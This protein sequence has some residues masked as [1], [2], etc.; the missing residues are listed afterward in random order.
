MGPCCHGVR[1]SPSRVSAAFVLARVAVGVFNERVA[2][3]QLSLPLGFEIAGKWRV[4][5]VLGAGGMGTVYRARHVRNDRVVALKVLHPA[6][7]TDREA[8]ERFLR[9]GYAANQVGHP[10]TVQVLDDGSTPEGAFLVMDYLEGV[11]IDKLAE[12]HRDVLPLGVVLAIT[13]AALDVLASAHEKGIIHRDLKPENLFLTQQGQLKVLDFGLARVRETQSAVRLTTTGVLMG[14]PAFMPPEQALAHWDT[15]EASSDVFSVG[16]TMWTL[17]TGRLVHEAAS[18]TELLV[19]AAMNQVVGVASVL[20]DLPGPVADV[21]DRSLAF[22]RSRRFAHAGEMAAALRLAVRAAH[23]SVPSLASVAA[24]VSRTSRQSTSQD[25]QTLRVAPTA[26][27]APLTSDSENRRRKS[28][29]TLLVSLAVASA[30]G[31]LGGGAV[32]WRLGAGPTG[33]RDVTVPAHPDVAS[34]VPPL[35]Q[36]EATPAPSLTPAS[37]T[38]SVSS[39]AASATATTSESSPT[40]SVTGS[41]RPAG[42]PSARK[43]PQPLCNVLEDYG[44]KR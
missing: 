37:A 6:L 16:A 11:P 34:E 1:P 32:F 15:V 42:R 27:V 39:A 7:S 5:A 23:V 12:A 43:P 3:G 20:A 10:G 8:R 35:E 44:C 25:E 17:L 22:D 21:I 18:A 13:D 36:P 14:T 40:A 28:R 41:A 9:E 31:A 29:S 30:I 2:E 26:S 19:K 33:P 38:A 24:G 4:E